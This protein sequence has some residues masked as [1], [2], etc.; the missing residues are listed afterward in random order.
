MHCR[1]CNRPLKN[2]VSVAFGMGAI[3]RMKLKEADKNE[4]TQNMF[5]NRSEYTHDIEE[6]IISITDKGGMKSVTNDIENVIT[7]IIEREGILKVMNS[8][9]IYKDSQGVWDGVRIELDASGKIK[10]TDFY[11]INEM[12]YQK[13]KEKVR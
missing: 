10:S 11:S 12:D 13:A 6:N 1:R 8:K 2:H 3:C 5:A 4:K 7:D 9:I